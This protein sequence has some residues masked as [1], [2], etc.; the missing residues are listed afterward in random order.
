M[1]I[2]GTQLLAVI[3]EV[4]RAATALFWAAFAGFAMIIWIFVEL[5]VMGG[6]SALHG[7]YFATGTLQLVLVFALLG[8]APA[9]VGARAVA[10]RR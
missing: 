2:G 3:A 5:A 6:F 10:A 9:V 4:R 8:I 1:V 7:I